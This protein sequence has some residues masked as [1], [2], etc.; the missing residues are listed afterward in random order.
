MDLILVQRSDAL[1]T[2]T[3]STSDPGSV[4]FLRINLLVDLNH[5]AICKSSYE[6][7]NFML[8]YVSVS[9]VKFFLISNFLYPCTGI[10]GFAFEAFKEMS[11]VFFF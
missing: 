3:T 8:R 5:A 2:P 10:S 7:L 9:V 4:F 11:G 6:A 1:N